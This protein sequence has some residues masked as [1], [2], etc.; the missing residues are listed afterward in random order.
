M[1]QGTE[2][3]NRTTADEP[4]FTLEPDRAFLGCLM[5]VSAA[6]A[7]GLL[8]GMRPEDAHSS[9][10]RQ[11]LH[12]AIHLTVQD[13]PCDP[14]TLLSAARNHGWL[15]TEHHHQR[16]AQWLIETYR[17]APTPDA[18]FVIKR[19]LLE[20]ALRRALAAQARR[21]LDIAAHG[22]IDR[23]RETATLDTDRITDLW[24]RF[25]HTAQALTP[26]N[27]EQ[28]GTG[29]PG[30]TTATD[31]DARQPNQDFPGDQRKAA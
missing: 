7:Q 4:P 21:V 31:A 18:A 10:A 1:P 29:Q 6:T 11:V 12:L 27:P 5:R 23:L 17:A 25:D 19:D 28:P 20:D 16:F 9:T 2:I 13:L 15:A 24:H 8:A 30:P 22:Q 26:A 14:V 3:G